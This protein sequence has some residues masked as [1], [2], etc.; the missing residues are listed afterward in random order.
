MGHMK[1]SQKIAV[2]LISA[3]GLLALGLLY[4]LWL[5][6]YPSYS[7]WG[8]LAA[9]GSTLLF[10]VLG[11]C[12][13]PRWVAFWSPGEPLPA[14][15]DTEEPPRMQVRLFGWLLAFDLLILI[16]A[17]LLR[18]AMGF[19][20]TLDF[21][22]CT[23]SRHY[24]DIARDWYLSEGSRDRLVQLVFLPGYPVAVRLA[25]L[26]VRN[27]L[28]AGLLVSALCFAGAG[29]VFYRLLR[30][31]Y[32]HET[33]LRGVV[34][35]CLL[36][37]SFFFAAPMSE[38]LFF[39]LCSACLYL[40][41]TRRWLLGSLCGALAAFTRSLGLTLLVPLMMELIAA[42]I[43]HE[44]SARRALTRAFALL[45]IPAGFGAYLLVNYAVAGDPFQFLTYQA[46][47]WG[48]HLGLFFNTAAYQTELA[49]GTVRTNPHNFW[50]LWLPNLL[51]AFGALALM[52]AAVR[53]LR[54]GYVAWFIAYYVIAIGA[55]W[56]LSAPRYLLACLPVPAAAS[57]VTE[58]QS[59]H[60]ALI[61]VLGV[62]W[63]LYFLAFLLRWQ[64]W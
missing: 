38:S 4:I 63:M 64:V 15:P 43:R 60:R 2:Y 11:L 39:L 19:A 51:A 46:E 47:H 24:L 35:L 7:N 50:G 22:T 8:R 18:R 9:L 23:D 57:L 29:C 17:W 20:G 30:L 28:R 40:A 54:P 10:A 49:I 16:L 55:T 34:L 14:A 52:I 21:W 27:E 12:F 58:R 37:G 56:L 45:L 33:A 25:A 1:R 26:V 42:I 32:P 5:R 36:P 41:R 6:S 62:L 31:D 61:P 48:Q 13:V 44:L 3:L 53:K 59:V